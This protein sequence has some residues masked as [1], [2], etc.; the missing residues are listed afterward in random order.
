MRQAQI[1]ERRK[2]KAI[3]AAIARGE[4]VVEDHS[5]RVK[6][7]AK[8]NHDVTES[9]DAKKTDSGV[10]TPSAGEK[11]D[12]GKDKNTN[13]L[14]AKLQAAKSL[15]KSSGFRGISK[16]IVDDDIIGAIDLGIELDIEI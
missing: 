5:R 15:Q 6:T 14:V 2:A 3:Q 7:R 1:S 4:N 16:P 13:E 9:F 10:A 11:V 8:T 12:A